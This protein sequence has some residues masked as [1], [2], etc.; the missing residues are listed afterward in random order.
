M[1]LFFVVDFGICAMERADVNVKIYNV[2]LLATL[3][4]GPWI[5]CAFGLLGVAMRLLLESIMA[6]CRQ[7][8]FFLT[9]A[10]QSLSA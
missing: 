7:Y 3:I 5:R 1:I 2:R 8:Y 6:G 4:P 10:T 9:K